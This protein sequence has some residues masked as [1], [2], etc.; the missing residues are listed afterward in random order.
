MFQ[1]LLLSAL[2]ALVPVSGP[3]TMPAPLTDLV[4]SATW[5]RDHLSDPGLV[6]LDVT[7]PGMNEPD[8]YSAGHVRGARQLD[9]HS[10]LTGDGTNGTLTMELVSPDSLRN[11]LEKLG[12]SDHSTIVL[13]STSQW[14]SPVARVYV[15]LDNVGLGDRT[16]ILDGGY[17]AWK[18]AGGAVA[19]EPP[20]VKRGNLHVTRDSSAVTNAA[21]VRAHIGDSNMT[22][23]DA[24]APEFYVGTARGHDAAR[25]G[26]VPGAHNVYFLTLADSVKNTYLTPELARARFVAAG[27]SLDKPVVVYCHIGQ[28]ASVDYVQLRRLGI[29]VKLYDGSFEDWS[30]HG[31]YPVVMG[32]LP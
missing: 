15:E 14:I 13:Y 18:A 17:N 10:I 30:R 21:Y 31:N 29:P 19:T 20:V 2:S 6:V 23:V 32:S 25:T 27:V 16:H 28:T 5:L 7:M 3:T 8:P 1:L 11:V 9:F 4:V 12:V 22:I 26:H 24:R